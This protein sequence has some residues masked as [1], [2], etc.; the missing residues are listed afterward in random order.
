LGGEYDC[1]LVATAHSSYDG[2]A[3]AA[4]GVPVVDSRGLVPRGPN[5]FRA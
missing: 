3:I 1:I 2:A 5:V 4:L